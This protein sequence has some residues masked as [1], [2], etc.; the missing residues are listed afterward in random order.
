MRALTVTR[1]LSTEQIDHLTAGLDDNHDNLV[2]MLMAALRSSCLQ[3]SFDLT[4]G[5]GVDLSAIMDDLETWAESRASELVGFLN[6]TSSASLKSV[7]DLAGDDRA[8]IGGAVLALFAEWGRERALTIASTEGNGAMTA[9]ERAIGRAT[10]ATSKVWITQAD[11]RVRGTHR[12]MHGQV[13]SLNEPFT[14]GNG[15]KGMGPG[16]FPSAGNNVNCRC[17]TRSFSGQPPAEAD[18]AA[19]AAAHDRSLGMLDVILAGA[20][21]SVFNEQQRAILVRLGSIR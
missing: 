19:M 10:G 1:A 3:A 17:G 6:E 2:L 11:E 12:T 5:R 13:V 15:E 14:A 7:L 9:V 18:L 4:R 16:Q 8:R 21:R 20:V